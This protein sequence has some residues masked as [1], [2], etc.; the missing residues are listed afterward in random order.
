M[1]IRRAEQDDVG[2]IETVLAASYSH[3]FADAY[4]EAILAAALPIMVGA[5]PDLLASGRFYLATAR[6]SE[7][8]GC[9]GWSAAVP[10]KGEVKAR[11]GHI[12]HF[13]THPD[14]CGRG[15]GRMIYARCEEQALDHGI[16][17]FIC[18]SSVNAQPFYAALGFVPVWRREVLLRGTVPFLAMEM[19]RIIAG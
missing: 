17:Q 6:D 1:N 4:D 11:T 15:V 9:G 16:R 3:F 7:V 2:A 5:N 8:V 18:W 12:R 14:W 19:T 13:A 10:G